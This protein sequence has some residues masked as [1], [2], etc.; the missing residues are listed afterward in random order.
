MIP[1]IHSF[2]PRRLRIAFGKL[3]AVRGKP[4]SARVRT[5]S[6]LSIGFS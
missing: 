5:R 6:S 3:R 1:L 4:R 2:S